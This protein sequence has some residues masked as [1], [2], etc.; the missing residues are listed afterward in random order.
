MTREVP[1]AKDD[2]RGTVISTTFGGLVQKELRVG[3]TMDYKIHV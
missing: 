3:I 1:G 2:K